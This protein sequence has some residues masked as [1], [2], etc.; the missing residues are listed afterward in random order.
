M[1]K[2]YF[3]G[4]YAFGVFDNDTMIQSIADMVIDH[5]DRL[6]YEITR[7]SLAQNT[8]TLYSSKVNEDEQIIIFVIEIA[9]ESLYI[10]NEAIHFAWF[11]GHEIFDL[12][13]L[14]L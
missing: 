12:F 7:L 1:F 10:L 8:Y 14:L 2:K 6:L 11:V 9:F 5:H 13:F 3:T 4:A